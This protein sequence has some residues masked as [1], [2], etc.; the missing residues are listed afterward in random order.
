LNRTRKCLAGRYV[1]YDIIPLREVG[2]AFG[3]YEGKGGLADAEGAEVVAAHGGREDM[4]G[5]RW[6]GLSMSHRAEV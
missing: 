4:C 2:D 1:P 6:E 5:V 3:F